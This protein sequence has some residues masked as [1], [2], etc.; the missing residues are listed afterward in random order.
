MKVSYALHNSY[1]NII[2]LNEPSRNYLL[3]AVT[4]GFS[5][6]SDPSFKQRCKPLPSIG[7][8]DHD[9]IRRSLQTS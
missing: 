8:S 2:M 6:L 5:A 4:T 3:I 7:N 9:P 1:G